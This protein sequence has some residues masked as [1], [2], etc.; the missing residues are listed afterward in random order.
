MTDWSMVPLI[1]FGI[2]SYTLGFFIGGW[3][4]K[5]KKDK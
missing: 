5:H 1:I 3:A 2:S 4:E